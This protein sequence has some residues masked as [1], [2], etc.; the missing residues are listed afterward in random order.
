MLACTDYAEQL[1]R[2]PQGSCAKHVQQLCRPGMV[3]G[4]QSRLMPQPA[5]NESVNGSCSQAN[6]DVLAFV[7][8]DHRCRAHRSLS[9][10]ISAVHPAHVTASACK[11]N[12]ELFASAR[13]QLHHCGHVSIVQNRKASRVHPKSCTEIHLFVGYKTCYAASSKILG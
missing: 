12:I 3:K 6:G 1:P 4:L 8:Q 11:Y 13:S 2:K 9:V 5:Y 10:D 7:M